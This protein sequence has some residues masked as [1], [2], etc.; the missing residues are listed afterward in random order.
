MT[1]QCNAEA[2]V[3]FREA[4]RLDPAQVPSL[5]QAL[6]HFVANAAWDD[7]ATSDHDAESILEDR[8]AGSSGMVTAS[9]A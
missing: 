5:H 4:A 7:G 2:L 9:A 1:I 6:H 3:H 8:R